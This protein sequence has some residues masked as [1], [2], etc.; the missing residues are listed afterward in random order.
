MANWI[1]QYLYGITLFYGEACNCLSEHQRLPKTFESILYL[2][3][4][5]VL[6]PISS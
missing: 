4:A 6:N 3:F 5:V 2:T 1:G